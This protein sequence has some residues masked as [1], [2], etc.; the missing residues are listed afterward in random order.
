MHAGRM[1]LNHSGVAIYVN[2][3]SREEISLSMNKAK[4]IIVR[5]DEAESFAKSECRFKPHSEEVVGQRRIAELKQSHGNAAY[6]KM[7]GS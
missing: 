3:Q 5:P 4:T 2:H 7:S 1:S 6:L